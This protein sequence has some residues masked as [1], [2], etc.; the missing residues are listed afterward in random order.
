MA[1]NQYQTTLKRIRQIQVSTS[2]THLETRKLNH[3]L[4]LNI[5]GQT[6][7][8]YRIDIATEIVNDVDF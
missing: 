6:Q 3:N 7:Q 1:C 4:D 5:E 8:I 2:T